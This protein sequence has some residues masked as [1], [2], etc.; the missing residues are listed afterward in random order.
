MGN[1]NFGQEKG[2]GTIWQHMPY[3][4]NYFQLFNNN[5]HPAPLIIFQGASIK[6]HTH[7]H[8]QLS[9]CFKNSDVA[10]LMLQLL[11]NTFKLIRH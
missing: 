1:Q 6:T 11:K 7:T 3:R 10:I 2:M 8:K 5:K 4:Q 9:L